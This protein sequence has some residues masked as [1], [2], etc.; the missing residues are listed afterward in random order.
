[1]SNFDWKKKHWTL[2]Q[3]RFDYDCHNHWNFLRTE[4]S[5]RIT[6]ESIPG[7]HGYRKTYQW[8]LWGS[9]A[10]RFC[11]LQKMDQRVM[12]QQKF[13]S[14]TLGNKITPRQ[15]QIARLILLVFRSNPTSRIRKV[16]QCHSLKAF[17]DHQGFWSTSKCLRLKNIF[18]FPIVKIPLELV[19]LR[20]ATASSRLNT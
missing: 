19:T 1:M 13:Y 8:N 3:G 17:H 16:G 2:Y 20:W 15:M 12:P 18:Y 11:S 4:G 7:W 9:V 10:D 6:T 5:K 14:L